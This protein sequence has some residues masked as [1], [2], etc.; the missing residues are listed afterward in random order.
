MGHAGRR[1]ALVADWDLVVI[2]FL[3]RFS[4][5]YISKFAL[6][7]IGI[8]LSA[9]IRMHYLS[10]LLDQTV[11]VLDT[12]PPGSAAGTITSAANTLQIGISEKL[13]TFVEFA[14]TI[15]AAIIVAFTY[16]WRVTLVTFS[17]VFF[18]GLSV[19][20]ILP[21]IIKGMSRHTKAE[22]K[23][24]AVATEAFS[25]IRMIYACGAQKRMADRYA[26]YVAEA[27]THGMSTAPFMATQFGLIF[28]GMFGAFALCFW[29]GTRAYA[30]GLVDGGIS[31][32]VVVLFN[33]FLMAIALERMSTPLVAASKATVAA[34]TFFAVIDTPKPDRGHLREP[35]VSAG[36]D[37][38]F[39]GVT[40]AYPGRP[41]T[42]V[43]DDLSVT[44]RAGKVTAIVGPSGSG[45][46]TIVGLVEKWYSL[47]EQ[48]VIERAVG[49]DVK[50]K[51][52][53]KKEAAGDGGVAESSGGDEKKSFWAKFKPKA[54]QN[55][56]DDDDD[57]DDKDAASK[58]QDSGPPVQ[59]RGR[60][61]TA[62][63]NLDEINVKW[64]RSQIGLVQQEP[65]LFNDSIYTNVMHGLV[66]TQWENET[67]EVKQ[68]LVREAC[69]EAFADE[70]IDR[71]PE[72]SL[73]TTEAFVIDR[74]GV[75]LPHGL[76]LH[77]QMLTSLYR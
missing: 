35:E 76:L 75:H 28:F 34:A 36:G 30:Q 50:K 55:D 25:A 59:L 44:I 71:L 5:N 20:I 13:G 6:R 41:S 74:S 77:M 66:G 60:I 24:G 14:S 19:G 9:A 51:K 40:F 21:F 73:S 62:G 12:M 32:I 3:V 67:L 64:W 8:R 49:K 65:F 10:S 39:D 2:L 7:L 61:M 29:Y 33:V 47:H 43:L 57:E 69:K 23:A 18:I 52:K 63:H 53:N 58:E 4:L 26:R 42:K 48:V 54:S 16:S 45:K 56:N 46:S 70:F 15:V 22:T 31:T 11:H 37:I 1:R 68:E 27:K 38:V 72:V 17:A